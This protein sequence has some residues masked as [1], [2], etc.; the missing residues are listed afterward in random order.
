MLKTKPASQLALGRAETSQALPTWAITKSRTSQSSS[1]LRDARETPPAQSGSVP[2]HACWESTL[3]RSALPQGI[4]TPVE[5]SAMAASAR[6]PGARR[7]SLR[8]LPILPRG[9]SA[10]SLGAG[11]A[12]RSA[13]LSAVARSCTAATVP[14][15]TQRFQPLP[16]KG[17]WGER[18]WASAAPVQSS[19]RTGL[20]HSGFEGPADCSSRQVCMAC[21]LI[22]GEALLGRD[23]D[24]RA[25][26][27]GYQ[28]LNFRF[29]P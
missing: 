3:V 5:A 6:A 12:L 23:G 20:F 14:A 29:L 10:Y 8:P 7:R 25:Q 4:L 28:V 22:V 9:T 27:L 13:A 1:V 18:S 26:G 11:A 2:H 19:Q 16:A 17:Q 15:R 24:P 21:Q